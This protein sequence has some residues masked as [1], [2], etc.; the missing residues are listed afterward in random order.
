MDF[1][2]D[3]LLRGHDGCYIVTPAKAGVQKNTRKARTLSFFVVNAFV[4]LC[5]S[6][7]LREP[8]LFFAVLCGL[9][10]LA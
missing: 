2:L 3:A 4:L 8:F 9:C 7:T 6:A 1:D 5:A 10:V